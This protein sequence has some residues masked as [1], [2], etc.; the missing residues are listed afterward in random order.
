MELKKINGLA[1]AWDSITQEVIEFKKPDLAELK[2]LFNE[3]YELAKEYSRAGSVPKGVCKVLLEM[4]D[5]G[6]WVG[7][8]DDTPIHYLYREIID[9]MY[10]LEKYLLTRDVNTEQLEKNINE[11][12]I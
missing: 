6:W 11:K 9:I 10:D 4:H 3:T 7:D 8:L 2:R 1:E 12:L 5:F